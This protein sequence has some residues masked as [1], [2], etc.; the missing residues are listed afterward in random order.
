MPIPLPRFSGISVFLLALS[1]AGA[2]AMG[3]FAATSRDEAPSDP[4]AADESSP[5][6]ESAAAGDGQADPD[7]APAPP[8]SLTRNELDREIEILQRDL[9]ELILRIGD[10]QPTE[11]QRQRLRDLA[12]RLAEYRG[13]LEKVK[14]TDEAEAQGEGLRA[15]WTRLRQ[16][17]QDI[18]RYDVNDGMFRIQ[19][20]VRFQIDATAGSES[21]ALQAQV[22]G[23]D[24]NVNI[25]RGRIFA[26]G[27]LLRQYDF[28]FEYDFAADDGPK[29]I[30]FEGVKFTRYV[31][32]RIGNFREPFSLGRQTSSFDH[33]FLERALSVQALTP[34]RNPG[35]MLRHLEM[36]NRLFWA[37]SVTTGGKVTDD[38][39][40]KA[41]IMYSGRL[42]GLALYRNE[43]KSL[44]HLGAS[45][46]LRDPKGNASRVVARPEARFAPFFVD[47][48]EFSATSMTLAG[49]EVAM[50]RGPYWAQAE[51]VGYDAE[52]SNSSSVSFSGS[53][54]EMGWFLTGES[55][56]YRTQ[57]GKFGRITPNRLFEGGNPFTGRGD[58]GAL[59]FTGRV[60]TLDLN[61]GPI[62]GG[63]ITDVSVGM[64]W[65]LNQSSRFMLN[66][67][68]SD[69]KNVGTA[70]LVLLRYQFNP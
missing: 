53:Y 42:T 65:Y 48:G 16:A 21:T 18:T 38:N 20:G 2:P 25:R 50:V 13:Q 4:A 70:D 7:A 62:S 67:I 51:W 15:R 32:W 47:T 30:Y 6:S 40:V 35:I 14:D 31:K 39:R 46:S 63:E 41:R 34:G 56:F 17:V 54:A 33:G 12:A 60:S 29:D 64:N 37:V 69:V 55:K 28:R 19:L 58:G 24:E 1:L 45:F 44:L 22:G 57:D 5:D 26:F 27:R 3:A 23:V 49:V 11:K 43:G 59:E 9:E 36:N 68:R 52:T 8:R 10:E 61:S 66:V